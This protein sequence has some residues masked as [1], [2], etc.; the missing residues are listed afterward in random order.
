GLADKGAQRRLFGHILEGQGRELLAAIDE[1]YALGV[2]PLA[3]MRAQM[4]LA[5]RITVAQV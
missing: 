3:L 1:Q 4:D 5:H 2:E